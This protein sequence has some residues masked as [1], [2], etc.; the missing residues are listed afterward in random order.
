MSVREAFSTTS[1]D[2]SLISQLHPVP[3]GPPP[4]ILLFYKQK[5]DSAAWNEKDCLK[6]E[7]QTI[8][9]SIG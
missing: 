4:W 7:D 2:Y 8:R 9:R 1:L 3:I 5:T 6:R